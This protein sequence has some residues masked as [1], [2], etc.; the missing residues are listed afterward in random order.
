MDY[1][2]INA[3]QRFYIEKRLLEKVTKLQIAR[4][5]G[6]Y[7][8]TIGR[9]IKCNTDPIFNGVYSH[10]RA[11]NISNSR[12]KSIS[13]IGKLSK[14]RTDFL[15]YIKNKISINTS[16]KVISGELKLNLTIK[17]SKNTIY[18]YLQKDKT[19]WGLLYKDL[20]HAGKPYRLSKSEASNVNRVSDEEINKIQFILNCLDR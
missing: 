6:V 9:E 11:I 12:R 10:L 17:V 4:E 18:R 1:R 2:H 15:S 16:P 20:I 7:H 13:K 14:L 8:S 19:N 3:N 5:L